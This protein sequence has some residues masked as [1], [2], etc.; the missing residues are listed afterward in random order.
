MHT[1]GLSISNFIAGISIT[2]NS[3]QADE[4][5]IALSYHLKQASE[6]GAQTKAAHHRVM[7]FT[8]AYEKALKAEKSKL[9][10]QTVNKMNNLKFSRFAAFEAFKYHGRKA[11][12]FAKQL[13]AVVPSLLNDACSSSIG[14]HARR[15]NAVLAS[16]FISQ[17][18]TILGEIAEDSLEK[19]EPQIEGRDEAMSLFSDIQ[20]NTDKHRFDKYLNIPFVRGAVAELAGLEAALDRVDSAM[21]KTAGV[22]KSFSTA[23]ERYF[24]KEWDESQSSAFATQSEVQ[25]FAQAQ[26]D[27]EIMHNALTNS[28]GI[29]WSAYWDLAGT[30]DKAVE[31]ASHQPYETIA[32]NNLIAT[33]VRLME[34]EA[35][36]RHLEHNIINSEKNAQCAE[37]NRSARKAMEEAFIRIPARIVVPSLRFLE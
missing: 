2:T 10:N 18:A 25:D 23:K 28:M 31:T 29:F 12:E 13:A 6:L 7:S 11:V 26:L 4:I 27:Y 32:R 15:A 17:V 21:E 35:R 30:F 3:S 5:T 1:T 20:C 8:H 24:A 19:N 36:F 37:R 33:K 16:G 9:R 22:F 34:I 14:W